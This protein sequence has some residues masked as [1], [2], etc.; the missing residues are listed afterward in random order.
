MAAPRRRIGR[1]DEQR[2]AAW[3]VLGLPWVTKGPRA[4]PLEELH[5]PV[6]RFLDETAGA[7]FA[8]DHGLVD[9]RGD[10]DALASAIGNSSIWT[11]VSCGCWR[12]RQRA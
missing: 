2:I 5:E 7:Q 11:P 12:P 8:D 9:A 4:T 6:A 10:V 1:L 3:L